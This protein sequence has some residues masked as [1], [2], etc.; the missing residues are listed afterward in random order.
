MYGIRSIEWIHVTS[1]FM[2][3]DSGSALSL[4]SLPVFEGYSLQHT[5]EFYMN[6]IR[7][8]YERYRRYYEER[9]SLR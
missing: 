7:E 2:S 4:I 6:A 3:R 9:M 1:I 5:F 8:N